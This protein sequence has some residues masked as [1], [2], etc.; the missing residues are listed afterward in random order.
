MIRCG[1]TDQL[2]ENLWVRGM[3]RWPSA[4]TRCITAYVQTVCRFLCDTVRIQRSLVSARV[5]GTRWKRDL[6]GG[7]GWDDGAQACAR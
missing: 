3:A 7:P 1:F 4:C 6:L 5:R 2:C